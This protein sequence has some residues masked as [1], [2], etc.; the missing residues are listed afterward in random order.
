MKSGLD[1]LNNNWWIA[2]CDWVITTW[3]TGGADWPPPSRV[4]GQSGTGWTGSRQ[5]WGSLGGHCAALTA[6]DSDCPSATPPQPVTAGT[7]PDWKRSVLWRLLCSHLSRS[8]GREGGGEGVSCEGL[9]P[10]LSEFTAGHSSCSVISQV[11]RRYDLCIYR[12]IP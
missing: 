10:W 9:L 12:F 1:Q 6:P 4:Q 8:A 2:I 5:Q 7:M 3:G 11:R